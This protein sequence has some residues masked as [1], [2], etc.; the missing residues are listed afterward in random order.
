L[1]SGLQHRPADPFECG[2]WGAFDRQ[3]GMGRKCLGLDQGARDP[4][5]IEPGLRLDAIARGRTSKREAGYAIGQPACDDAADR[6]EAGNGD[7]GHRH[8][9]SAGMA[10]FRNRRACVLRAPVSGHKHV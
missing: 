3:I 4:F 9:R 10:G 1:L 2:G 5:G 8:G 6:A 7:T